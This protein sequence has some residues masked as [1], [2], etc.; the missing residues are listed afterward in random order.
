MSSTYQLN[1]K[2]L[3]RSRMYEGSHVQGEVVEVRHRSY[4]VI[5]EDNNGIIEKVTVDNIWKKKSVNKAAT[6]AP[7]SKVAGVA[8]ITTGIVELKHV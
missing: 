5:F 1:D 6:E 2:V 7:P 4:G 8:F 3:H